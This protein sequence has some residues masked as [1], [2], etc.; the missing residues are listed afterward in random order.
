MYG[1]QFVFYD[2]NHPSNIPEELIGQFNY[3]IIDPPYLVFIILYRL[4]IVFK[5][6][7]KQLDLFQNLNQKIEYYVDYVY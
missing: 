5:V 2:F 3:I 7:L 4:K 6:L 1:K